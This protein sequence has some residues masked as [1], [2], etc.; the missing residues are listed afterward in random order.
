MQVWKYTSDKIM[1]KAPVTI[2]ACLASLMMF[3]ISS[4]KEVM[5]VDRQNSTVSIVRQSLEISAHE[6]KFTSPQA[7][8]STIWVISSNVEWEITDV[9]DWITVKPKS[10]GDGSTSVTVSVTENGK[11]SS[12][13]GLFS[14]KS[15]DG[16]WSYGK[17]IT[18]SQVR[19]TMYATPDRE[20]VEFDGSESTAVVK[21]SSNIKDW[22]VSTVP[23]SSWCTVTKGDGQITL[24][25]TANTYDTSRECQIQISTSDGSE[26]VTVVQRP[27]NLAATM[28][29]L[30]FGVGDGSQDVQISSDAPWTATTSYSWINV[31]PETGSAGESTITVQVT[32]NNSLSTRNGYIYIVLSD[33]RKIEIPV[34]QECISFSIDKTLIEA[35]AG[36]QN[37]QLNVQ[38]NVAWK[39]LDSIPSWI[40]VSPE[41]GSGNSQVS[42]GVRSNSGYNGRNTVLKFAPVSLTNAATEVEIRQSGHTFDSDSTALHFSDKAS[43]SYF[44]ILSDGS[45]TVV[46]SASWITLDKE[47][48]TGDSRIEVTVTENMADTARTAY[49]LASIEGRQA[50]ITVYQQGKYFNVSSTALDFTSKGGSTLVTLKTNNSW[51]AVSGSDWLTLS[52]QDG[53]GDCNLTITAADN[54]SVNGRSGYV[55]ITPKESNAIRINVTQAAR[56]L[57]VSADTI[58]FFNKGGT[59]APIIITTDGVADVS[60][61]ADWITI[62]KISDTQFTVTATEYNSVEVNREGEITVQLSGLSQGSIVKR[63]IVVQKYRK[64]IYVDL[65][66]SVIWAG[67]NIGAENPEDYGDFYAWG[68]TVPYLDSNTQ[69]WKSGKTDGYIWSS[70]SYCSGSKTS[71]T[72][73]N[74]DSSM[75]TVDNKHTLEPE[76]DVAQVEWGDNWRIPTIDEFSELE[77]EC[78]WTWTVRNG[79]NGYLVTSNV[80]G[81]T[82]KSIFLPAAGW[83][84]DTSYDN[85]GTVVSYWSSSLFD[86]YPHSAK[87]P[88]Y[89]S[90]SLGLV[91][92]YRCYGRTVRP[93]Y[94]STAWLFDLSVTLDINDLSLLSGETGNISATVKHGSDKLY[95]FP[96]IWSTGDP[97]I[98]TVDDQGTV[99]AVSAGST[100]ITATCKGKSSTCTITVTEPVIVYVDLGLS[101]KWATCNVGASKPEEYGNYYAW[102]EIET[103]DV[104]NWSTYKW[105]NGSSSTLTK[106]N[107]NGDWGTIDNK[108][109]LDPEDDV[110]YVKWGDNWRMPTHEEQAELLDNCTWEWTTENGVNGCR[111]TSNIPGYTN[112]SIFL[113]AAGFIEGTSFTDATIGSYW[114][115]SLD[116]DNPSRAWGNDFYSSYVYDVSSDSRSRGFS[117]RPVCPSDEWLSKVSIVLDIESQSILIGDTCT[118]TATAKHGSDI[119]NREITWSSGDPSIAT[120]NNNGLV[121]GISAGSTTITATCLG[122]TAVCTITV[123]EPVY[124]YVDLGL[125]VYWAT[126]NIGA[127][128]PESYGDFYAWGETE[129]KEVYSWTNYKFRTSGTKWGSIKYSKY[130]SDSNSGTVDNKTVLDIDDDVAHVKWGG[131]WRMPTEAEQKELK[132]K[133]TWTWTTVNGVNGYLITSNIAGY[134]NNSLFLPAAGYRDDTAYNEGTYG[135]YWSSSLYN[136]NTDY[137]RD[138]DFSFGFISIGMGGRYSGLPVRAVC[139]SENWTEPSYTEVFRT[140]WRSECVDYY[141]TNRYIPTSVYV[142]SGVDS[143]RKGNGESS[144][145]K[146]GLYCMNGEGLYDCGFYLSNRTNGQTGNLYSI[147]TLEAGIYSIDFRACGWASNSRK[148]IVKM[149]PKP[150][151]ELAD[152]ND[153]GFVILESI[154]NKTVIGQIDSWDANIAAY[155][156]WPESSTDVHFSFTIPES[157]DYVVEFYTDGSSDYKGVIFSNYSIKRAE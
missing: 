85:P 2:L 64:Y 108:T 7:S 109:H 122:K 91:T 24:S 97:S 137:A 3:F 121:T 52:S 134:E 119:L 151:G 30:D 48:G 27:A 124:E 58:E 112:K 21:V 89:S 86:D 131:K 34:S 73:Y 104:Y 67:C 138:F 32:A 45:W 60:A 111:V 147:V 47:S 18:V 94:P 76:D 82:D 41:S 43:T 153:N 130:N 19:A 59:S 35:P 55:D 53:N 29:R 140:D 56:Y 152:G 78:T 105:C 107:I 144:A 15:K 149:Y 31:T 74:N 37:Y 141:F 118:L 46:P 71:L 33:A 61:A 25:V 23:A 132:D 72:K 13:V 123:T 39:L 117:V 90:G 120:V 75:G 63:I 126:C 79:V 136:S 155:G 148:L 127:D 77:N 14:F 40:T 146:C 42:I 20:R 70:Y 4:C 84:H 83:Y 65:G 135:N 157:G 95:Y 51:T 68:E 49:I 5:P 99:T 110:A 129:T 154:E 11:T 93:V 92:E 156:D 8:S 69:N 50:K 1:K 142:H 143:F 98:A 17:T 125:S 57:T 80:E 114:S 133:C 9:P 87:S 100:T 36:G 113:P 10:G 6:V 116:I 88:Y 81:Y 96:V 16:S 115:S 62:N 12:R 28:D 44:N 38:S 101:V 102:G 66:L 54:P 150:A 128:K 103:K 139:P 22:T 145:T 106:Y 26:F